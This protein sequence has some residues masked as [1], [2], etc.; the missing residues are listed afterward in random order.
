MSFRQVRQTVLDL[1][2]DPVLGL[3]PTIEA[4]AD[5]EDLT[6]RSDFNYVRGSLTG[7]IQTT[8]KPNIGVRSPR[9][10]PEQKVS[11]PQRDASVVIEVMGEFSSADQVKLEEQRDLTVIAVV[12]V[13]ERL[14]DYSDDNNGTI[15]DV[16]DP[17]SI[18]IG[19]FGGPVTT[20]GFICA[21]TI[22]ERSSQ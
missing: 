4:L 17:Y 19:Q 20:E 2:Q 6:V 15:L 8:G 14:R 9:W 11:K 16:L 5:A 21:T 7:K 10:S 13:L 12:Q 1:L 3:K 18:N 22:L